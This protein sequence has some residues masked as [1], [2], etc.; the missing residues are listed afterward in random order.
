MA[1]IDPDTLL[2]KVDKKGM[3]GDLVLSIVLHALVIGLT[4]FGLYASWMKWGVHSPSQIK[5]L[6]KAAAKEAAKAAAEAKAKADAEAA[7][8]NSVEKAESKKPAAPAEK[9]PAAEKKDSAPEALPL[10]KQVEAPPKN[11]DLNEIDL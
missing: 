3:S 10:D 7:A 1:N 6:E 11:F 4:S 8:T 2:K 9:K 5:V